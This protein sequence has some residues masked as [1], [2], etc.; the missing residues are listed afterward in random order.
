MREKRR[1]ERKPTDYLTELTNALGERVSGV[2]RDLSM[3]AIHIET[4]RPAPFASSVAVH[5]HPDGT[6]GSLSLPG[7]V[8]WTKEN[9]MGVQLGL[10]GARETH[11]ISEILAG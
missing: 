4:L 8:R 1:H 11:A 2:C 10:L 7:I 5:I 3:G 6:G 9:R